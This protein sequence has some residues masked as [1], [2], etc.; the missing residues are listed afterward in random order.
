[1]S[2]WA[3]DASKEYCFAFYGRIA[4]ALIDHLGIDKMLWIGTSM[5]G[6]IGAKLASSELKN[7]I[8]KLVINDIGPDIPVAAVDRIASYVGNPPV[9]GSIGELETWLRTVYAPFG[10]NPDRF[11]QVMAESSY[12]RMDD[13]RVT[14]HYDPKIVSQFTEHGSDLD[15]WPAFDAVE[16]P[17]LVLRGENSDVLPAAVAQEMTT[18]GPKPRLV[19]LP[20]FGHAPTLHSPPEIAAIT[21][22]LAS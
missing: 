5:G 8:T 12:R 21:E 9:F 2:Q 11:W 18:R 17:T 20:G 3:V 1:M 14:V 13:G 6:L 22:F 19:E 4:M 16:C 15:V 7:R 10:D